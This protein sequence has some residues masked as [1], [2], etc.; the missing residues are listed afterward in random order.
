MLVLA[1]HVSNHHQ[2]TL[3]FLHP[4]RILRWG[5][6]ICALSKTEPIQHW[7]TEYWYNHPLRPG[8]SFF[9]HLWAGQKSQGFLILIQFGNQ[10]QDSCEIHWSSRPV[11]FLSSHFSQAP[12]H[13]VPSPEPA[14]K[15]KCLSYFSDKIFP[16]NV[17]AGND[18][19]GRELFKT[20]QN[21]EIVLNIFTSNSVIWS[22]EVVQPTK[23]FWTPWQQLC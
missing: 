8:N 2:T 15:I 1:R 6:L 13:A 16:R 12:C 23:S 5:T 7:A 3:V 17:R 14:W 9:C 19:A 4:C 11:F 22:S 18:V 20:Q 21:I 10:C